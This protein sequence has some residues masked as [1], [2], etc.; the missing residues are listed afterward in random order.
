MRR[1]SFFH[2][3][4]PSSP[5]QLQP[6]SPAPRLTRGSMQHDPMSHPLW[7]SPDSPLQAGHRS[8]MHAAADTSHGM[9]NDGLKHDSRGESSSAASQWQGLPR[10]SSRAANPP[11]DPTLNGLRA[12]YSRDQPDARISAA[13]MPA[14]SMALSTELNHRPSVAAAQWDG[15]AEVLPVRSSMAKGQRGPDGTPR[16]TMLASQQHASY[17]NEQQS[18]HL[19]P[20]SAPSMTQ[21]QRPNAAGSFRRSTREA[22][23]IH[24]SDVHGQGSYAMLNDRSSAQDSAAQLHDVRSAAG[25]EEQSRLMRMRP[26]AARQS[27]LSRQGQSDPASWI[28]GRPSTAPQSSAHAEPHLDPILSRHRS[29]HAICSFLQPECIIWIWW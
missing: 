27:L 5:Q 26:G 4:P 20:I 9:L 3:I 10:T 28:D 29:A 16:N 11:S 19:R 14:G 21:Q 18:P 12:R 2:D 6:S 22:A 25:Q 24:Q 17:P 23:D 1:R 15:L 7:H 13:H 8:S